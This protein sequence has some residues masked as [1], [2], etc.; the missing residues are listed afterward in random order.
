MRDKKI[1]HDVKDFIHHVESLFLYVSVTFR[2][3]MSFREKLAWITLVTVLLSFGA[4]YG[5]IF[6]GLVKH[7][8]PAALHLALAALI[9]LVLLQVALTL[10]A[11]V[12]T[13]KDGR[14]PRDEREKMIQARSHTIGYYTLMAATAALFIPTH[15][16][17]VDMVDIV[18]FAMLGIVISAVVVAVAQIVM[19]RR[20]Y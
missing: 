9:A 16:P 6:G 1:R 3:R 13:P 7:Y 14:G 18:N 19:F 11:A 2:G 4:Y 5:A 10:L 20:G 15:A 17:G 8:S 12:T